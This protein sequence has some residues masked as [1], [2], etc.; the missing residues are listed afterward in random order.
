[1]EVD[2]KVESDVIYK[3]IILYEEV[4]ELFFQEVKFKVKDGEVWE[5][6]CKLF[7]IQWEVVWI[8]FDDDFFNMV[9][10]IICGIYIQ[11]FV[12]DYL[13]VLMGFY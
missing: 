12:Y 11:I 9:C 3:E 5:K 7:E 13:R 10:F 4:F 8:K 6:S 2:R 1:M